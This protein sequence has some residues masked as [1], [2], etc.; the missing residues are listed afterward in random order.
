MDVKMTGSNI[1]R[2]PSIVCRFLNVLKGRV[3]P[4]GS[5]LV[6]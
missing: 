3:L 2:P 1:I 5:P 4:S 6:S